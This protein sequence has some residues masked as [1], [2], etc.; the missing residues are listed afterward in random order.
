MVS[1]PHEVMH[2]IFQED[3]GLFA[4]AARTIG[5]PFA[6]P[7]S[8][9]LLPTD[10]TEIHPL[11]RRVDTVLSIKTAG[12]EHYI[13]AV[14]AQSKQDPD[15]LASWTYYLAYLYA[16]YRLPPVLAVVCQDRATARWAA[17]HVDIGPAHWPALTLRPMVL[18]PNNI[19]VFTTP[20]KVAQDPSM[21]VLSA[22]VHRRD[23]EIKAI[24]D[25]MAPALR[26][27][28]DRDEDTA[29]KL[30]ELTLQGLDKTPAADLWRELMAVDLSF[31]Q[32]SVA[33]E[34]RDEGRAQGKAEGVA[35]G[36]A[37]AIAFLLER[38]GIDLSEEDRERITSCDDLDVLGRWFERAITAASVAEVFTEPG[39]DVF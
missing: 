20:D 27:L 13:L 39:H 24:L 6:D 22:V 19:P 8:S 21:S 23:P 2:R 11:E 34:L 38:R 36:K 15:K 37:E 16:K 30:I 32:S 3:P 14:E 25:A 31:F 17:R 12:S 10:V 29:E 1:S 5:I 33:D 28:Q 35:Q 9:E 26:A 18:G 4:R 7:V